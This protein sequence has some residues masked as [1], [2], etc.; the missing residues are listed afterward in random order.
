MVFSPRSAARNAAEY[1]PGPAPMTTTSQS[2][3]P[4]AAGAVDCAG[5]AAAAGFSAGAC[6]PALSSMRIVAPCETLSP[7]LTL[8]SLTTPAAGDGISIVALSDSSVISDCSLVTLSPGLTRTSM[9]S[10]LLKSPMSGTF[11]STVT[12]RCEPLKDQLADVRQHGN[13]ERRE[14]RGRRTVDDAVVVG[15]RERQHEPR[16]EFLSVPHRLHYRA[17]YAEDGDLGGIDDRREVRAADAAE[18]GN[19]K[20]AA[21]QVAGL[22]LLVARQLGNFRELVREIEHPLAIGVAHHRDDQAAGR[23]DRHADVEVFL[24]DD[25]LARFI[26]RGVELRVLAQRRHTRLDHEG[27]HRELEALLLR[28]GGLRLAEGFEIRDVGVIALRDVRDRDPV[29][30]Q[31]RPRQLLDA[32][33]RLR[34]DRAELREIDLRPRRQ[35]E[36]QRTTA[37]LCG[38]GSGSARQRAFNEALDVAVQDA[39]FRTAALHLRQV[40]AELARKLAHRGTRVRLARGFFTRLARDGSRAGRRCGHGA[41]RRRRG[42]RRFGPGFDPRLGALLAAFEHEDRRPLGD[43]VAV[44]DLELLHHAGGGGRNLHRRLV[45][46]EGDERLLLRHLVARL[47]QHLDHLDFLEV[48]DVGHADGLRATRSGLRRGRRLARRFL[49]LRLFLLRL[50]FLRLV[51]GVEEQDRHALRH[52]VAGLH[53]ELLHHP[54]GRRR[55]LHRRLV[56]LER[57]ERLLLGHGVAR[58]DQHLDDFDFLEVADVGHD[59]RLIHTVT[60]SALS[61]SMPYFLIA[62]ATD[63]ALPSPWSASALSAAM[64]TK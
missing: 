30:V 21:L 2:T 64:V 48:A 10:T 56:G 5:A 36:G 42:L 1:P 43:L 18:A 11:T 54:R 24:D 3:S 35:I 49:S 55:D 12:I 8:S 28:L 15:E 25:V 26:E 31:I 34:L 7:V 58:L 22:Q 33:E 14:A 62:S 37:L 20:G 63:F 13:E 40:D 17:R 4:F 27:E 38:R 9:T 59:Y 46:L 60:G 47:D 19:G 6:A 44:L 39:A 52:L 16:R 23:V 51:L 53:L 32:R 29:A 45:G 41:R 50:R 57:D 61:G